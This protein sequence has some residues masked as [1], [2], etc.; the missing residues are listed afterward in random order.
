MMTLAAWLH[1]LDPFILRI[2]GD[3]G[4]RWYGAAYLAGFA[5]AYVV[6]RALAKR[7]LVQIPAERVGDAMLWLVGGTLVGG[8][9]GYAFVYDPAL[10]ARF[11]GTPPWWALLAINQGGMASH[12]AMVGLVLA[13]WRISRGWKDADGRV[14]GKT[15][16]LHVMDA[17]VL[18]APFGVFL[19]R[20]AN[21]VNGELLGK[22]VAPPGTPGPW[23]SVQYPQELELP[24]MKVAQTPAQ[25][26]QVQ[27]LAQ[28]A[29]PGAPLEVGI[30]RLV[31]QP[32]K[33]GPLLRPLLSSRHPSQL[34]QAAAEG[35][36]IGVVLWLV[37]MRPRKPGVVLSV[38]LI[39]Y[40]V[41][42]ILTELIRL[43]DAQLVHERILG[44]SRGQWLSV[45][46]VVIGTALLGY[47]ARQPW[48]KIGGWLGRGRAA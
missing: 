7:G 2:S 39:G 10:F 42:R 19:G 45:A 22:I 23:W 20:V 43:P 4:I 38:F 12:G 34:Y 6:L 40:G 17:V 41:L 8:R 47:V 35:I 30:G 16:P 48:A 44:L 13:C 9:L 26:A 14:V 27:A 46:M 32:E 15:S 36:V 29:A 21:F 28:Q 1:N 31:S 37:W 33:Y 5:I 25:W 18:V 11:S 3:F 24:I